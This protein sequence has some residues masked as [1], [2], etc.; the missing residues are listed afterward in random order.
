MRVEDAH[1]S[2]KIF[3]YSPSRDM[4]RQSYRNT[5]ASV[6]LIDIQCYRSAF[7]QIIFFQ[8][9]QTSSAYAAI[10]L[11]LPHTE[12]LLQPKGYNHIQWIRS[13][14]NDKKWTTRCMNWNS[15]NTI[16]SSTAF[17][18]SELSLSKNGC[19]RPVTSIIPSL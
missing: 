19:I 10:T 2:A 9:P 12:D 13:V 8:L 11:S 15:T 18:I 7:W 3:Q 5:S 1:H 4:R 6:R 16:K 14:G 17:E